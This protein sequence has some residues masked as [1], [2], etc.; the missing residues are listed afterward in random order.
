MARFVQ[1]YVLGAAVLAG[2]ACSE[3]PSRP[4]TPPARLDKGRGYGSATLFPSIRGER[5]REE[6]VRAAE[7]EAA[8]R[9]LP[10]VHT[11]R[12]DV[13]LPDR[14][15]RPAAVLVAATAA[16]AMAED[17]R[18]IA[19]TVVPDAPPERVTVTVRPPAAETP[20]EP[21]T[22]LVPL[23]LVAF[24]ASLGVLGERARALT[25]QRAGR[26]LHRRERGRGRPR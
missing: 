19:R 3:G 9:A 26:R 24:G 7:I 16:P 12:A 6:A 11:V 4:R 10:E 22:P 18:S 2:G 1:A 5:I 25:A 21:P 20:P 23:L 17:L 13:E 15:G 8:A 14:C